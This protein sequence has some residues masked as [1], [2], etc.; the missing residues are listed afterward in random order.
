MIWFVLGCLAASIGLA[1][2]LGG[3]LIWAARRS[4]A[5]SDQ[6]ISHVTAEGELKL[7]L[8]DTEAGRQCALDAVDNLQ[9]GIV[10]EV[11]ARKKAEKHAEKA[12]EELIK[13]GNA[14]AAATRLRTDLDRLRALSEGLPDLPIPSSTDGG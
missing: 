14:P 6:V 10:R 5:L 4:S 7:K 8:A 3:G 11:E 2:L 9:L 1:A 12:I 13:T